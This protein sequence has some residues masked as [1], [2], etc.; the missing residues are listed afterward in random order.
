M[1]ELFLIYGGDKDWLIQGIKVVPEKLQN[2]AK[3]NE[4]MANKPQSLRVEAILEMLNNSNSYNCWNM[5]ELVHAS[6][7]L[8]N[9]HKLASFVNSLAIS[10]SFEFCFEGDEET[11]IMNTYKLG[12]SEANI[13]LESNS[14]IKHS[15]VNLKLTNSDN[16]HK[17]KNTLTYIVNKCLLLGL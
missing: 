9:F 15:Y 13:E 12:K 16:N 14:F 11:L 5:N 8:F 2:I 3:Y 6:S 1:E 10:T 4:L 17:R 7:I